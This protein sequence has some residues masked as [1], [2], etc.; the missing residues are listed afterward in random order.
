MGW[1]SRLLSANV[2]LALWLSTVNSAERLCDH[3]KISH[4]ILYDEEEYKAFSPVIS[5]KVF[6]YS[7]EYNF[8]SPSNS[9]WTRITCTDAGWSPTPKCL[10]LCFFPF[11]ENG[12]SISSGQTHLQGDIVQVVCNPGYSLQN[13]QNTIECT[14]EGWSIPPKCVSTDNSCVDPPLVK[15]ATI[16]T[17]PMD[18]Y[19]PNAKVRYECNK[20]FELFGEVEVM[21][22]NGV[23]TEPPKCKD[24]TGK[25]G[26]PPPIDNGDI[27]SFPL[28]VYAPLSSVEYQCQS[29]YQLQGNKKI[30]CRNG[31]WSEPPKC[32]QTTCK[33]PYIPNGF[34]SPQ[35][36]KHRADD[37]ITYGCKEGFYPATQ[38]TVVKCTS[39]GWIPAP[40]CGLKPCDFPQIK[41][42]RLH[43]EERYRPYFPVSIGKL[44]YYRCNDGFLAPS[45][46]YLGYIRC[47]VQGWEPA[48]PCLRQCVFHEV[49]NGESPYRQ[50][51]Y[52]QG[53]SAEV[54]CY[55]GYSLPNGQ[56]TVTC[57]ENGWSPQPKCIRVKTCSKNDIEIENGFL[58]ESDH[59]YA[60]NRKTHYR[61]KQGYVTANGE[62]SGTITCLQNGWSAQPSCI[63]S[64]DRP[65]FE[66]AGTKNNSTW[67]KLNDKLDYECHIVYENK[68]KHTKG[69]I[70][71]TYDGWSDIPSCYERECSIPL[72]SPHLF[73]NPRNDK[74]NVGD[75]LKFSCQQGHRVG[76]D[77][78]QCYHFGWSPS[79]P[80]CKV[81]KVGPCDQPPKLLNG[82][83]KGTKKEEYGHDEVVKYDC[84]PGFLLKGPSK[85]QCVDGN[86]TTLPMCV[87]EES[88]CGDIPEIEHGSVQF[89]V[90][91]YHH[92]DSVE[93]NCTENFTMIGHM[94]VSCMRG[95]WTQL[96]QCVATDQ[97]EK[98]KAPKVTGVNGIQPNK[99][100]FNHNF[101]MSY[102][103]RGKKEHKHSTCINGRWDPEPNCREK[104]S[105][106]PPPQ[107][108]NAQ[109][110]KTTVK[111]QDGEKVSVLCQDNYIIQDTEEMVCRDGRW[112]SLPRCIVKIP[113][114]Q[115]P[116]IDHGSIKLPGVSE[117][118]RD[119]VESRIHEHGTTLS[120]VCEDGF[121]M[122]E[123]HGVTCNM[124][125]W[126]VP[127]RCVELRCGPPP[128]I[129]H[130]IVSH[131]LDSYQHGEEVTYNCAEG[132]GIDGPALIKCVGGKWSQPPTCMVTDC[133]NLPRFENAIPQEEE[134]YSYRS[135]EQVTFTCAPSYHMNG[136]NI[137]T[138]V[139]REWIGEVV[140][141]VAPHLMF[142]LHKFPLNF[143]SEK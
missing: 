84:K 116:E 135:G 60:L 1:S 18:K 87:E 119:R 16:V 71:C 121:R 141:K 42:G 69:S 31:E 109:V 110:M 50:I 37:E 80:T 61:C 97:L 130:G 140:C 20:S 15:N 115:P 77:S 118:R 54:K 98:C 111:Y 75:L 10:R 12:N 72:L 137:V 129:R 73:V 32:L 52:S 56:D 112:Q 49:E 90:P 13:N 26:P 43:N 58:S 96:P 126:S 46:N 33:P 138:C 45:R 7:C 28:P 47:T 128:S 134:K 95:R 102:K 132:F 79:F 21:C 30:T 127:P 136:S 99:K 103:C 104:E 89:F 35:R 114:S 122:A 100:E 76:P 9:I 6:Y 17:R 36:I 85:I 83:A 113:C 11:V 5:G 14:E 19:P 57:T 24:S 51:P 93:F 81:D 117:E 2:F 53:E 131:E 94:S 142:H 8:V 86:W 34:Y 108:P 64:C 66:N 107:I 91:P 3:P 59:T 88:T 41:N 62:T 38:E 105:C 23:W 143:S 125:K 68:Y 39:T 133:D 48:V 55:P 106:P 82:E 139:N 4:G 78:V 25:C 120:Y 63:K 29:L 92:G 44:F 70:T 40:R 67:F 123:E 101:S 22:Q 124:G 65:I 74:Y 27:T